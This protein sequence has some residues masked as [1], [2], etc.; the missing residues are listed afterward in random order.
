M[1]TTL[2]KGPPMG[3]TVMLI[4]TEPPAFTVDADP[5]AVTEKV[6]AD[7]TVTSSPAEVEVAKPALPEYTAV[8][9]SV[10]EGRV[11]RVKV[12]T[13]DAFRFAV[14]NRVVP[15]KKLTVPAGVPVGAGL[16]VAVKSDRRPGCC[17]IRIGGQ[18][19]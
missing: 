1:V 11:E 17:R 4:S 3:G 16:T 5:G 2:S 14:P 13:P 8:I 18:C 7:V 15:L 9:V 12:A 6:E 19:R 10:P